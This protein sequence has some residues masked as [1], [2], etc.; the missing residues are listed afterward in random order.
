MGTILT[1]AILQ[2]KVAWDIIK[3]LGSDNGSRSDFRL[4]MM[5]LCHPYVDVSLEYRLGFGAEWMT[6]AVISMSS[7]GFI[8]GNIIRGIPS[9]E[10][11]VNT[12][13][14][15][16]YGDNS[17][18][19]GIPC[20][21]R[22]RVMPS[23]MSF[24]RCGGYTH[25]EIN[26]DPQRPKLHSSLAREVI[27]L[28]NSG[29]F[30]CADAGRILGVDSVGTELY[31]VTGLSSPSCVIEKDDGN[32]IIANTGS[33]SIIEATVESVVVRTWGNPSCTPNPRF[34]LHD[35]LTDNI[36]VTDGDLC[37]AYEVSWGGASHGSLLWTF[38]QSLSGS[39]LEHLDAPGGIVYDLSDRSKIIIADGGNNRVLI[40]D[41]SGGSDV[42][43][44]IKTISVGN[45]SSVLRAPY[46]ISSWENGMIFS[47]GI[48]GSP[49]SFGETR[50]EHPT[51][52]RED[53]GYNPYQYRN[54]VFS[55]LAQP[56][57]G[58]AI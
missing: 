14:R 23:S 39:D 10:A 54:I 42:T 51:L 47:S 4:Y 30:I 45:S 41:R 36:L 34:V 15:W 26:G 22:L 7:S 24:S 28:D 37:N 46:W 2:G 20:D 57:N 12:R 58:G 52:T 8:N 9:S 19:G 44:E 38:G 55:P 11:G 33:A 27:G 29:N 40:V 3:I 21:I 16:E 53:R 31:E 13:I 56:I 17:L 1:R 48:D 50:S 49:L 5:S 25:I 32:F 43:T 35:P 18:S 6:D